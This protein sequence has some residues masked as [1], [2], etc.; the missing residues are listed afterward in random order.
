MSTSIISAGDQ[1][2]VPPPRHYPALT[3]HHHPLHMLA[4]LLLPP[5]LIVKLR[6]PILS[7]YAASKGH[8]GDL[9]EGFELDSQA[10]VEGVGT[11]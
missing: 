3:A 4:P 5:N 1:A 11:L 9:D 10:A 6:Y 8:G 7:E 2:A